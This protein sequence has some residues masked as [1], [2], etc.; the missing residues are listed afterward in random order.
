[1]IK[2]GQIAAEHIHC[3]HNNFNSSYVYT[4]QQHIQQI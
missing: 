1:M 4:F 2:H 3:I